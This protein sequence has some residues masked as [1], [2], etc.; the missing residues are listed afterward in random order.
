[1]TA[2]TPM[3]QRP[4]VGL[5]ASAFAG[6]LLLVGWSLDLNNIW[7]VALL[8]VPI[9][10]V[11]HRAK[12]A[13]ELHDSTWFLLES[14]A[15]QVDDRDPRTREH[16][17]RV[18]HW[19]RE[20]L[21]ELQISGPEAELII[22]AARLHDIGKVSLPDEVLH[23]HEALTPEEWRIMES[24]P[25]I[26]AE[27]VARYPGFA[28]AAGIIRHH[29]ERLDGQGYPDRIAGTAIP[30]GARVL[31]VAD[32]FDA[33]TRDRPHRAGMPVERATAIFQGGSGT[34]WDPAVV[35]ALLRLVGTKHAPQG[36]SERPVL[37]T[38]A[39]TV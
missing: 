15:D 8:L 14:L 19:T 5:V 32:S 34:Q 33:M 38:R 7:N 23:K 37:S 39:H 36:S 29:H 26:G 25:V 2:S 20:L 18:T 22:T 10:L 30:F 4:L 11:H 12:R 21:H 35:D 3:I 1:M 13:R 31:S 28:H 9:V 6:A 27:M 17:A 24:H 16:S